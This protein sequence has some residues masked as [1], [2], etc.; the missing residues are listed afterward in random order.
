MKTLFQ[1]LLNRQPTDKEIELLRNKNHTF[2]NSYIVGLEEYK[3]FLFQNQRN[4]ENLV[5]RELSITVFNNNKLNHTLMETLRNENYSIDKVKNIILKKK[6][7]IKNKVDLVIFNITGK[8]NYTI[9]YN[10]FNQIFINNNF[11]YRQLEFIIVNSDIYNNLVE[12]EINLF[13]EKNKISI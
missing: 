8:R 5:K 4:V 3:D 2:I 10:E 6:N 13:Y 11:D 9:N 7:E 1:I 12:K